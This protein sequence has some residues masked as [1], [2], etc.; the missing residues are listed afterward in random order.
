MAKIK[1]QKGKIN[2]KMGEP[3]KGIS[4]KITQKE[5]TKAGKLMKKDQTL[6]MMMPRK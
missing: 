4:Q 5:D 3:K 1:L 6:G 2:T